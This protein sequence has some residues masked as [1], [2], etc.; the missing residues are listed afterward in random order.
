MLLRFVGDSVLKN[1]KTRSI[2][3]IGVTIK[4]KSK[5]NWKTIKIKFTLDYKLATTNLF[6]LTEY[7][8]SVLN[9]ELPTNVARRAAE[10]AS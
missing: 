1:T 8:I 9:V 4:Q 6:A 5:K 2:R 7:K 3:V 10:I